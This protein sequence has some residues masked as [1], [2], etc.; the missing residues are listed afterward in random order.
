MKKWENLNFWDLFTDEEI[1]ELVKKEKLTLSRIILLPANEFTFGS[2]PK[3]IE[4]IKTLFNEKEI[5]GLR[6]TI[7]PKIHLEFIFWF[8]AIE[9]YTDEEVKQLFIDLCG[10]SN[11]TY[12]KV[13]DKLGFGGDNMR[14]LISKLF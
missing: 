12:G 1:K 5:E 14:I 7:P 8:H 13:V 10:D 3:K 11:V 9:K 6:K 2:D 4:H